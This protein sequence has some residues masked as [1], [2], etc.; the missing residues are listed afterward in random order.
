MS[1]YELIS[2]SI[3][4]I[5]LSGF[6]LDLDLPNLSLESTST[7]VD[8]PACIRTSKTNKTTVHHTK[9][10]KGEAE[11]IVAN[12]PKL[13]FTV[14]WSTNEIGQAVPTVRCEVWTMGRPR[15]RPTARHFHNQPE[16]RGYGLM[17]RWILFV[18][19]ASCGP[20]GNTVKQDGS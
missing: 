20:L 6:G 4:V 7:I 2:C 13:A 16:L 8:T 11:A 1:L 15:C 18:W 12:F 19:L 17:L 5:N 14:D 3:P 10:N 9:T